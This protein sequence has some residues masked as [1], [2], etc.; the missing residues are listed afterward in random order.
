MNNLS[1]W[2]LSLEFLIL[3]FIWENL[4]HCY[5]FQLN[6]KF[7]LWN[8]HFTSDFFPI[9]VPVSGS[10]SVAHKLTC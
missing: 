1:I 5:I 8:I 10:I 4:Y 2:E 7:E 9:W 6:M 3:W